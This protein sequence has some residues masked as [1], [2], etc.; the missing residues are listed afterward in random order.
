M[1][2]RPNILMIMADQLPALAVGA[3][4]HPTIK[5]P[6]IDRLAARGTVFDAAY[7]NCPICAPSRA[8]MCTGRYVSGID[9]F[10]NGTDFLSSIPTFMH[11]L[12]R[13]GYEILLSGKMHFLGPDQMHGFERRLTPEIYPSS[14]TWTPDW[15]RGAYANP[16]SNVDQIGESGVSDWN[17]QLDYDEEVCF[18]SEEALRRLARQEDD[19][20][21]FLCASFTHP[22]DPFLITQE[23]WDLYDHDSVEMP[24]APAKPL[25]QMH[26]YDQ[27]L[28]I[29]HM[30]DVNPPDDEAI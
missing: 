27:W 13:A 4:G 14:F 25:D 22:H 17:M 20:P 15:T 28:Q 2:D 12:T 9:A 5:T 29:H 10:D 24:A 23:Y 7:T 30:A 6:N 3:Y 1:T 18:R 16:G 26:P 21:F 11:H 19:R 8:S